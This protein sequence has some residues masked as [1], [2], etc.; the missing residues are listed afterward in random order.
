MGSGRID[1]FIVTI[2]TGGFPIGTTVYSNSQ[3]DKCFLNTELIGDYWSHSKDWKKQIAEN[4]G[5]KMFEVGQKWIRRDGQVVTIEEVDDTGEDTFTIEAG[6]ESYVEDG[7]YYESKSEHNYDLMEQVV[8]KSKRPNVAHYSK[9]EIQSI[10]LI[11]TLNLNFN[12]GNIVKYA[13]RDKSQDVEDLQKI[14][15]YANFELEIIRND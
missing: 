4:K 3:G 9:G 7:H 5:I 13:C 10:D 1:K 12:M 15:D 2:E 11:N 6:G 14:I 8:E